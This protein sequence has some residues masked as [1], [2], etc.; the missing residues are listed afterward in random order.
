M[1]EPAVTQ[2]VRRIEANV[3]HYSDDAVDL[4]RDLA[5]ADLP[6]ARPAAT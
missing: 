4:L 3:S 1:A 2:F 6:A 5:A